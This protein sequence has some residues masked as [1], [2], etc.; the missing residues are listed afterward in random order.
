MT[1][2]GAR[3]AG[4][5]GYLR[6]EVVSGMVSLL[7]SAARAGS[8]RPFS[9]VRDSVEQG[10]L[11]IRQSTFPLLISMT[12]FCIG[13]V[14]TLINGILV[15]LGAPDRFAGVVETGLIRETDVWVTTM[16]V[17]GVLGSAI[18]ADLG[19][20]KVREELDAIRVLGVDPVKSLVVPRIVGVT[21]AMPV[22][23]LMALLISVGTLYV[24]GPLL[25]P[26]HPTAVFV[27]SLK[28]YLNP[29]DLASFLAKLTVF[30]VFLSVVACYKGM[31]TS[32]GSEGVGRAVNQTVLITF[33]A[34]WLMNSL[35]N[36][37]VLALAPDLSALR[38]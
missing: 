21:L 13:T 10:S 36:L 23:G 6:L 24:V 38:G 4:T 33:F 22:L 29:V 2:V 20:R 32:G 18:T 35:W 15:P 5:P 9:W 30:G 26:N 14:V 3:V 7:A 16:V 34:S 19:S 8:R 37:A 28:T 11:A 27:E 17:A 31:T 1:G 25:I 12:F